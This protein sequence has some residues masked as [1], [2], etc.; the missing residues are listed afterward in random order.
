MADKKITS[1]NPSTY[2]TLGEVAYTSEEEIKNIIAKANQARKEWKELGL[3]GRVKALRK[4]SDK[5]TEKKDELA[6]LGAQEMGMPIS[7]SNADVQDGIN[8]FNWYLDNASKYLSPEVVYEDNKITQTVY[9]E[10]I[11]TAAVITP[12][13]FP[14]SNFVWGAGQNLIAGNT[15]IY[16]TSE[17]CPLFGKLLEETI[18]SAGLPE[19][20]FSE[21][22]GDGT[23]GDFL[24]H[25]DI[26]LI[27]FT[28]ST[29][30]GKYL[31]Q[32]GGEKFIKVVCELG[33]SAPGIVFSDA[34]LDEVIEV[35]YGNRFTNCGQMCDALKRLIV[36]D[37]IFDKVAERLRKKLESLKV[38]NA[39]DES[40]DI[41]PLVAKRQLE[42]LE[43]QIQD[44][45]DK[46]AKVIIGGK[47]PEGLN[48]AYYEPTIL[49]NVTKE[50]R[51]WQEEVF[52]P[53]LPIVAFDT[54]E[55][56]VKMANDTNYGLGSYIY[57][58][59]KEKALKVATQIEAGM[60]SINTASYINACSP[61]GGYKDSGI[62]REH[63]KFG[64]AEL[65]QV[66]VVAIE[67]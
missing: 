55:K 7:Q 18:N 58:K 44:A 49:T 53:V 29:K 48:G 50:M 26:N 10:P 12:W 52:G 64:F 60:V 22:Y 43:E 11:G 27:S 16:K 45:V 46:G 61:F 2:E 13:N 47:R 5:L 37:S 8:F 30:V 17:E 34:D 59:D 21:I 56:S 38:G 42:L 6:K 23:V 66:K 9:Y 57:T 51:V 3:G 19:G 54:D 39:E 4:V 35:I 67:K 65:T 33:G 20:V 32:V 14:V 31:Y 25:Q 1:I 36:H 62:G 15:V 24:T 41:G 40:T 63:G 28:G